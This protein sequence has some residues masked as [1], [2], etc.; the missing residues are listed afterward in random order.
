[1]GQGTA[2]GGHEADFPVGTTSQQTLHARATL[3]R[4]VG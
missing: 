4:A 2:S 1:M 3:R